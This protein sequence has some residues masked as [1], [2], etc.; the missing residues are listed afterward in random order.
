MGSLALPQLISLVV[1]V[2]A[3]SATGGFIASAVARRK[4]R[5]ARGFFFLGLF[6]GLMAGSVLVARRHGQNTL[7]PVLRGVG[8]RGLG[9]G[10]HNWT[11]GFVFTRLPLRR[12]VFDTQCRRLPARTAT[13]HRRGTFT[14]LR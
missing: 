4:R 14:R 8:L 7:G 1:G 13:T 3:I 6:C 9:A 10:T 12:R 11:N 2:A 5:R